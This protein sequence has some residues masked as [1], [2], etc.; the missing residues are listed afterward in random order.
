[1]PAKVAREQEV[2]MEDL[3]RA[4]KTVSLVAHRTPLLFSRTFSEM[5]GVQVYLKAENLQRTGSFKIRGAATKLAHLPRRPKPRGVIAASAGNHAQGVAL[6]S[7]FARIPC[8]L[9]MP[10]GASLAKVEAT[11]NYGA[12]VILAGDSYDEAQQ[13][14]S[15]LSRE[16]G[17]V[18]VHP[19]DDPYIIAGQGTVGLEIAEEMGEAT[20]VVPMGGGGLIAGIALAVKS[21]HPKAQVIGVQT[22]AAPAGVRSFQQGK[23][24]PTPVS[25]SIADGIA[26][27]CPGE[28]PFRLIQR[29]V[30]DLVTVTEESIA[31]AMV[32][33]LE[34]T[35]L[36][37]E[38]AGAVGLAGL[39]SGRVRPAKDK[40]ALVLS[41]GN[42]DPTLL[43]RVLEH[44]L[45]HGGRYLVL[46]V[47]LVDRPGQLARLMNALAGAG[48]NVLEVSHQRH[49]ILLPVGQVQ[50][51][52]TVETRDAAHA[53][54]VAKHLRDQGY[55][56]Q[57]QS[58][59]LPLGVLA[60]T[61]R[62]AAAQSP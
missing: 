46:R 13:E 43:S 42:L 19:F 25:P 8:T 2:T 20:V 33:L 49:G 38:G 59:A 24:S 4:S 9:V 62:E 15:R 11:R 5:S 50:V 56:P 18:L 48:A 27:S 41:G 34:R 26:I 37:V 57:E 51:E 1:M 55:L 22:E 35:K 61:S 21:C 3:R 32:L 44:G 29:Y 6:A 16:E 45:A 54:A 12:R 10:R 7:R 52:V 17:L 47:L 28:L 31:H 39:L 14:A 60:F 30:D 53:E 40:V 23:P 36:L 58:Q